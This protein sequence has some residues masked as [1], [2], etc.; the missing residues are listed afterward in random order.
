MV[1]LPYTLRYFKQH[2]KED[3]EFLTEV[4]V[5]VEVNPNEQECFQKE[6]FDKVV[7]ENQP[8]LWADTWYKCIV[9]DQQ[10]REVLSLYTIKPAGCA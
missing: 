1:V 4:E 10:G 3:D 9:V 7:K 2:H 6:V 5:E 8:E